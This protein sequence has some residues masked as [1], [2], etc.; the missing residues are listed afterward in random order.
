VALARQTQQIVVDQ[1][2]VDRQAQQQVQQAQQAKALLAVTVFLA[3][4]STHA[5][6]V[7]VVV[8]VVSEAMVLQIPLVLV[9]SAFLLK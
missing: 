3:E 2:V 7:A 1:A 9:V 8:L 4:L 6:Q 5:H